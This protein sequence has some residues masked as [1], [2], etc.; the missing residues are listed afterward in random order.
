[1]KE[2]R[3]TITERE[4]E[5]LKLR[6]DALLFTALRHEATLSRINI[7]P[8]KRIDCISKS[9]RHWFKHLFLMTFFYDY[10]LDRSDEEQFPESFFI[11]AN[12]FSEYRD[13][14]GSQYGQR[15]L[16][17]IEKNNCQQVY[18]QMIEKQWLHPEEYLR[19]YPDYSGYYRKQI[20]CL[21]HLELLFLDGETKEIACK[22][23][24]LYKQYW[25]L[26]LLV[27]DIMDVK[28][29]I[30]SRTVTPMSAWYFA[31][32]GIMPTV[33]NCDMLR[34]YGK[35]EVDRLFPDFEKA[36]FDLGVFDF[37][38][39]VCDLIDRLEQSC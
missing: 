33:D 39:I 20:L 31:E 37:L 14:V 28:R 36:M 25:S 21:T 7:E 30:E 13:Y 9:Y 23:I 2:I 35:R 32:N 29:D 11:S 22:I 34:A 1:M 26:I 4:F 12:M 27:D 8:L 38:D 5:R 10:C 6:D 17:L 15:G 19:S 24:E 3:Y 16:S 18:Y